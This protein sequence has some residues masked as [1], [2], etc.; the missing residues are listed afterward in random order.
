VLLAGLPDRRHVRH[1]RQQVAPRALPAPEHV[2]RDC[3]STKAS[4][5]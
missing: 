1:G 3:P 2:L 4:R 5:K